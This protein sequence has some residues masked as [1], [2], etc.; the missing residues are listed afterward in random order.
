MVVDLAARVFGDRAPRALLPANTAPA[1]A[2]G[3]TST[4]AADAASS[5]ADA[6]APAPTSPPSIGVWERA[7][8]ASKD[9]GR[10]EKRLRIEAPPSPLGLPSSSVAAASQ[11]FKPASWRPDLQVEPET[12]LTMEDSVANDDY[13]VAALG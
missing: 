10:P 1:A 6:A 2:L 7:A 11:P 4:A 12:P 9:E 8:E 5:A 13:V 3:S